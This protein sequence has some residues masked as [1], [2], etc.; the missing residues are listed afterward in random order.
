MEDKMLEIK[1]VIRN[2]CGELGLIC[3]KVILFG[4]RARGGF[5]QF[6]DYDVMVILDGEVSIE[7]KMVLSKK[8]TQTLAEQLLDIDVIVK[9]AKEVEY[10][11][12]KVG[13]VVK[14][15]LMEGVDL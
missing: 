8:I 1:R 15:A 6:S 13:N 10:Y 5:D 12:N 4:S 2:F 11:G 7:D 3:Q 14:F 9:T